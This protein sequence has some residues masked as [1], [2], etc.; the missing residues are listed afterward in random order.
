PISSPGS[1]SPSSHR[2]EGCSFW[3][4]PG[5]TTSSRPAT[6]S[7]LSEGGTG[8]P[9]PVGEVCE[10][11]L[12]FR[13]FHLL[14]LV[15]VLASAAWV[16]RLTLSPTSRSASVQS[17]FDEVQ[18][19]YQEKRFEE[20]VELIDP[21]IAQFPK[22]PEF[23]LVRGYLYG[24]L[25]RWPAARYELRWAGFLASGTQ[26]ARELNAI[27][28]GLFWLRDYGA[29]YEN[30]Q[31]SL[32][33]EPDEPRALDTRGCALLG[34]GRPQEALADFNR[35]LELLPDQHEHMIHRAWALEDLGRQEEALQDRARTGPVERVEQMRPS[36]PAR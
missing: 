16:G 8:C 29:S 31:K 23:R 30:V 5:W 6:R 34:L 1:P 26:G 7:R 9:R 21:L 10:M 4:A 33:L 36:R 14:A 12:G 15:V 28:W 22:D 13:W 24:S 19:L 32:A 18:R 25:G 2:P 11:R 3:D 20:A 17:R 35:S 27:A